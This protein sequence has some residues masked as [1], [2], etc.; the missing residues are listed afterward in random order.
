MTR[1]CSRYGQYETGSWSLFNLWRLDSGRST[2]PR[3]LVAFFLGPCDCQ[4]P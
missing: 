4:C 3:M 1:N 2:V